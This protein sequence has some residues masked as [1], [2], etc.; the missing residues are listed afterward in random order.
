MACV[1]SFMWGAISS[2][3]R[4]GR[5]NL[6]SGQQLVAHV[7]LFSTAHSENGPVTSKEGTTEKKIHSGEILSGKFKRVPKVF[8]AESLAISELLEFSEEHGK[9]Q[10]KIEKAIDDLVPAYTIEEL[11]RPKADG[12]PLPDWQVQKLFPFDQHSPW[13]LRKILE[14]GEDIKE[15]KEW[16]PD[17]QRVG[18]ICTKLGMFNDFT[19]WGEAVPV[20]VLQVRNPQVTKIMKRPDER[21]H[22]VELAGI[23]IDRPGS[24]S[25]DRRRYYEHRGLSWK[26]KAVSFKVLEDGLLPQGFRVTCAHFVPGQFVDVMSK[27]RGKGFQ[28]VMKRWGFKGQPRSHGAQKVHRKPGSIGSMSPNRVRPGTKMA[29]HMGANNQ[30]QRG[31]K[32]HSIIPKH[33]LILVR[34][35][36]GGPNMSTVIVRDAVPRPFFYLRLDQWPKLPSMKREDFEKLPEEL[37]AEPLPYDPVHFMMRKYNHD[38]P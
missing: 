24:L 35:S 2:L 21:Y 5:T 12:R 9:D 22:H 29:G 16:A 32:V 11:V 14:V 6:R 18:V 17:S 30:R 37:K 33:D 3:P 36:V 38:L 26:K 1:T 8:Q 19:D 15:Y 20:T 13:D 34:G 31:L 25:L 10:K 23:D 27:S 7:R 4:A 28:G